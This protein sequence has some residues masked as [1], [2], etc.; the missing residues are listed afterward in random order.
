MLSDVWCA[1]F[2]DGTVEDIPRKLS[3]IRP[4]VKWGDEEDIAIYNAIARETGCELILRKDITDK[5][6]D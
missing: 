2:L 3:V 4:L 5:E 1:F 6:G